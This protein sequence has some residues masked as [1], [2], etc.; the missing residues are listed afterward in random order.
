MEV[1]L[2]IIGT[3]ASRIMELRKWRRVDI[4]GGA[5]LSGEGWVVLVGVGRWY[6]GARVV[7]CCL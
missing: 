2:L 4:L 6:G 5:M 1:V 7:E 3:A